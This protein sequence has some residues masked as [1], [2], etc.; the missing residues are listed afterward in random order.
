MRPLR[1]LVVHRRVPRPMPRHLPPPLRRHGHPSGRL[2]DGR[3]RRRL[4]R[5]VPRHDLP[6]RDHVRVDERLAVG[7]A[8]HALGVDREVGRR[9]LHAW[10]LRLLHPPPRLP[11]LARARRLH[12]WHPRLR[13]HGRRLGLHVCGRRHD[14]AGDD[15]DAGQQLRRVP[16]GAVEGGYD[17]D[18]L[19]SPQGGAGAPRE[20]HEVGRLWRRHAGDLRAE[21]EEGVVGP[22][23]ARR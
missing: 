13:H 5:R 11:L 23:E 8:V 3:G 12:L 14:Q 2:C 7:R 9:P 17:A 18:G 22:L 4:G 15:Q 20:A 21:D 16:G 10:D 1:A 6:R 19:R